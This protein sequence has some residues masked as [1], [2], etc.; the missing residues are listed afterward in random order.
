MDMHCACASSGRS[1]LWHMFPS[2]GHWRV[3]FNGRW[4]CYG[5]IKWQ[6]PGQIA[7]TVI[8]QIVAAAEQR[9]ISEKGVSRHDL[10]AYWSLPAGTVPNALNC[11]SLPIILVNCCWPTLCAMCHWGGP[12]CG[13]RRVV[14]CA[15]ISNC[16]Y[17]FRGCVGQAAWIVQRQC[18]VVNDQHVELWCVTWLTWLVTPH[19]EH[20]KQCS[21]GWPV[22]YSPS[23]QVRSYINCITPKLN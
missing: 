16:H 22:C 5:A 9:S 17:P 7:G 21:K 4:P 23:Q 18:H 12:R 15:E 20:G 3:T 10:S 14:A 2:N 11:P 19:R 13:L 1:R 6:L 8:R